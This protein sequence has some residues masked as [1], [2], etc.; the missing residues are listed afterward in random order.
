MFE[1]IQV[2]TKSIWKIILS[3][4][5]WFGFFGSFILRHCTFGFI[6]KYAYD[7]NLNDAYCNLATGMFM[8]PTWVSPIIDQKLGISALYSVKKRSLLYGILVITAI[9]VNIL[10]DSQI[11][12]IGK[13]I[14]IGSMS[15]FYLILRYLI[16]E[17]ISP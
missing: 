14:T 1:G 12:D 4:A 9:N 17:S 11:S 13:Y 2:K 3:L 6:L 10:L 8:V 7:N 16:L 15:T 5:L